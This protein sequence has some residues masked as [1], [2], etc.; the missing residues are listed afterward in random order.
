M[1]DFSEQYAKNVL[2]FYR[3]LLRQESWD[4]ARELTIA[5]VPYLIP[6][7][8]LP[9]FIPDQELGIEVEA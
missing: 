9:H 1:N 8:E 3:A 6:M 4:F 5:A 2:A 7:Q